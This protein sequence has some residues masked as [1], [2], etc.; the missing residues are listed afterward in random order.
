[1]QSRNKTLR[2]NGERTRP[3]VEMMW[4]NAM[5]TKCVVVLMAMAVLGLSCIVCTPVA[6]GQAGYGSVL[7]TVTDPQGAAVAGAEVTVIDQ[8][9]GTEDTAT[10]NE[11]ANFAVT[12]LVPDS[13]TVRV[14]PAG[15]EAAEQDGV[16]VQADA[17]GLR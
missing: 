15:F 10:T 2:K 7:G 5:R 12:Q 11:D 14:E 13:Y 1:M 4:R 17:G 16:V 8:Q 3:V 6:L 9:K